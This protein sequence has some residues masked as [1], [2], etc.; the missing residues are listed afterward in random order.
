MSEPEERDFSTAYGG[1]PL[2]NLSPAQGRGAKRKQP[3]WTIPFLRALE[4][5]GNARASRS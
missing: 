4:R 1:S 5:T 3:S 2:P